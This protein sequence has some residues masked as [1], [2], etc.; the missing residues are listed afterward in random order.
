[1]SPRSYAQNAKNAIINEQQA[2]AQVAKWSANAQEA[3]FAAANLGLARG[4]AAGVNAAANA[5]F[6]S[7]NA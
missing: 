1:M 2:A 5:D 4:V 7:S 6:S 3:K